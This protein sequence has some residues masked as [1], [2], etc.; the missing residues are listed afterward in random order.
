[1][2]LQIN[3]MMVSKKNSSVKTTGGVSDLME[4]SQKEE[5]TTVRSTMTDSCM[6]LEAKTLVLDISTVSGPLTF[7]KFISQETLRMTVPQTP[8]GD[9]L[10]Q[11]EPAQ[12][13]WQT[14]LQ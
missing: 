8:N 5:L 14:I 6:Y 4:D 1:M 11:L 9:K 3:S 2:Y 7:L 13:Q 12:S 10:K